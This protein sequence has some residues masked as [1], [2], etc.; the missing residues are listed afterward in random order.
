M[1]W[2]SRSVRP[3]TAEEWTRERNR[4]RR[5]PGGADTEGTI[6]VPSLPSDITAMG[7]TRL[8]DVVPMTLGQE[9]HAHGTTISYDVQ[10]VQNT[11]SKFRVTNFV[12]EREVPIDA[13]S[14]MQTFRGIGTTTSRRSWRAPSQS[15]SSPPRA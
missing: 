10:S 4:P 12:G 8:R 2:K 11:I 14:G 5:P 3:S 15:S 6:L 13:Y 7:R 9:M 1:A